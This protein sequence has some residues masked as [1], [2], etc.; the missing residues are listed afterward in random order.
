MEPLLGALIAGITFSVVIAMVYYLFYLVVA[1]GFVPPVRAF[2]RFID[3]YSKHTRNKRVKEK[4][5]EYETI[6]GMHK[7]SVLGSTIVFSVI[8][9]I[10]SLLLFKVVFFMVI[11]SGSM[12]PTLERGDLVLMQRIHTDAGVGDIITFRE[13]D[14]LLPITHR[15]VSV[16]KAG[17]RTKGDARGRMD[18]WLVPQEEIEAKAILISGKPIVLKDVGDYFILDPKQM[19]VGRYGTEYAFIKNVLITVRMYG[20]ALCIIAILGYAILTMKEMKS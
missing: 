10:I 20:Y 19:R 3:M 16:T 2:S 7:P 17:M 6:C 12:S 4:M 8:V 9:L 15:V 13:T 11:T 1:K 18:P 5:Y 14:V